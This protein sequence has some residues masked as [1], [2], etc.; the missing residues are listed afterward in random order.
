MLFVVTH[1]AE[2][3]MRYADE[4]WVVEKGKRIFCGSPT[5]RETISFLMHYKDQRWL[6]EQ[7]NLMEKI[8]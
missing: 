7:W 4:I 5:D 6:S 3:A 1:D 2:L 8:L